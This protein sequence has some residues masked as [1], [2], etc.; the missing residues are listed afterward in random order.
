MAVPDSSPE[1]SVVGE[2]EGEYEDVANE[3]P[4]VSQAPDRPVSGRSR[5]PWIWLGAVV[6][7]LALGLIVQQYQRAERLAGRVESLSTALA[8]AELALGVYRTRLEAVRVG[9][10]EAADRMDALRVLVATDPLE[11]QSSQS[12]SSTPSKPVQ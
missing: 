6:A 4:S 2:R 5:S 3:P 10:N 12:P 11:S 7:L 8:E 9:V 1:L